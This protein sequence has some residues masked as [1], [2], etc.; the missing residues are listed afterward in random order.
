MVCNKRSRERCKVCKASSRS[1][2]PSMS[3][4][5]LSNY[6]KFLKEQ[7]VSLAEYL[8]QGVE[9]Y[10][11]YKYI[12]GKVHMLEICQQE[13]SRLLEQEEKIDE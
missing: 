8:T 6:Q 3:L 9:N 5:V 4:F 2:L 7:H 13:I 1:K 12:L 11:E 10:E